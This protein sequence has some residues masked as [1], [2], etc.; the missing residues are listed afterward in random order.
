MPFP[1]RRMRKNEMV[2]SKRRQYIRA[3]KIAANHADD[4]MITVSVDEAREIVNLLMEQTNEWTPVT[5]GPPESGFDILMYGVETYK[6]YFDT[7]IKR[8][9][10]D[11]GYIIGGITHWMPLPR[12]P[13][14]E[15][16][17]KE[18]TT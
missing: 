13:K 18:Q 14:G 16:N 15:E 10:L 2:E 3:L 5:D 17:A 1:N 8:F 6:G 9:R 12:P 4:G 7:E 11:D